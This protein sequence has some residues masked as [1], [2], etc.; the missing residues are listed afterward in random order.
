MAL[1]YLHTT[2]PPL[3]KIKQISYNQHNKNAE[4]ININLKILFTSLTKTS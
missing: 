2:P 1:P 4:A 3:P